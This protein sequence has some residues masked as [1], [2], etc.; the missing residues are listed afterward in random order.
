MIDGTWL[1]PRNSPRRV[2]DLQL[3]SVWSRR[4]VMHVVLGSVLYGCVRCVGM[5]E[6]PKGT[7]NDTALYG[8]SD[9]L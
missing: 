2:G 9:K 7:A 3:Q 1:V 6:L 5:P 4:W 8:A